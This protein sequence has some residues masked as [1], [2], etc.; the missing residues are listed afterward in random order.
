MPAV[1]QKTVRTTESKPA[2][3]ARALADGIQGITPKVVF[4]FA[5]RQVDHAQVHAALRPLLPKGTRVVGASSGGE[6]DSSGMHTGSTLLVALWGDLDVG[7]GF[8][9]G[10]ST[11]ALH[12]GAAA[13]REACAQLGVAP[14]AVDKRRFVGV[15][16]DDG[17]Q[18]RKDELLLGAKEVCPSVQLVGGG[19][20]DANRESALLTVDGRTESDAVF[21]VLFR[22]DAPWAVLQTHWYE[23]TGQTVRVTKA[24]ESRRRAIE[25]DGQPAAERYAQLLGVTVDE[26]EF[27]MPKGFANRPTAQ[28][29]G[30]EYFLCSPWKPL[31][32]GSILFAGML[33]DTEL[34]IMKLG[35]MAGATRRFL[36]DVPRKVA[37]PSAGLLF[38]CS[39]RAWFAHASGRA[40]E[41]SEAFS[42]APWAAGLNVN[43]EVYRSIHVNTTLTALVFG[44][45]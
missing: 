1:H 33:P 29:L 35:D 25:L 20:N 42:I 10:L 31:P 41:L 2:E 12:A 36:Q 11:D 21:I 7:V 5:G 8:A 32:D 16:M 6:I 45:A 3:I 14:E 18:Y 44:N 24:D 22:T 26:L 43:F 9:R 37:N 28:R 38:H 27:G 13:M 4:V 40:G 19:A 23:P 34:E 39:G 30:R 17:F 15:V